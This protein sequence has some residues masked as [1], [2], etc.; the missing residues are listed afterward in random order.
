L[1]SLAARVFESRLKP[2]ARK[3][4]DGRVMRLEF[5]ADPVLEPR[6]E[7]FVL[8]RPPLPRVPHD[9]EQHSAEY[10]G[11]PCPFCIGARWAPEGLVA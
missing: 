7:A 11:S 2:I 1:A 5:G 3:E 10:R 8:H 9:V 4:R 6:L